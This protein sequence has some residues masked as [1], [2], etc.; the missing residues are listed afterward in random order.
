MHCVDLVNFVK[1]IKILLG[2]LQS[3]SGRLY[4]EMNT[5]PSHC[6]EMNTVPS[7][8]CNRMAQT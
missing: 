6:E 8:T 2:L 3:V 5:V 7:N 1:M 4:E